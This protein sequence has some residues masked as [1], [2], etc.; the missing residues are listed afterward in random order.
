[1]C[2]SCR[3]AEQMDLSF[4]S[5]IP[6]CN[7]RSHGLQWKMPRLC[8]WKARPHLH[9]TEHNMA[10]WS[11][12]EPLP[13]AEPYYWW[14]YITLY[15]SQSEAHLFPLRWVSMQRF[16]WRFLT[17]ICCSLVPFQS[18]LVI[19]PLQALST[20]P[21]NPFHPRWRIKEEKKMKWERNRGRK[22][23]DSLMFTPPF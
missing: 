14:P 21:H 10:K 23:Y 2:G 4:H 11:K 3:N 13:S 15:R 20:S 19:R 1:M 12:L 16:E 6:K 7:E 22:S 5:V 9:N 17:Y 18:I 8:V